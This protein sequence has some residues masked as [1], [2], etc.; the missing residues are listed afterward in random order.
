MAALRMAVEENW[1]G[2]KLVVDRLEVVQAIQER[3]FK[4]KNVDIKRRVAADIAILEERGARVEIEWIKAHSGVQGNELADQAAKEGTTGKEIPKVQPKSNGEIRIQ[5]VPVDRVRLHKEW[6]Y[7]WERLGV[8]V[9]KGMQKEWQGKGTEMA[10]MVLLGVAQWQ[11]MEAPGAGEIECK[12]CGQTHVGGVSGR[13]LYCGQH[14]TYRREVQQ[15]WTTTVPGGEWESMSAAEQKVMYRGGLA[16]AWERKMARYA[17][18][19]KQLQKAIKQAMRGQPKRVF[20]ERQMWARRAGA[21]QNQQQQ[22][23]RKRQRRE[24][25]VQ[26]MWSG[27]GRL[28]RSKTGRGAAGKRKSTMLDQWIKRRRSGQQDASAGRQ[29][30]AEQGQQ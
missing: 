20:E 9:V 14:Q 3:K 30:A 15:A 24:Y 21:C 25:E 26:E 8:K 1:R 28:K 12:E 19:G 16:K 11:G 27:Q 13:L 17:A 29:A 2:V 7:D 5:G 6:S 4:G 10:W 18:D 23:A 22:A